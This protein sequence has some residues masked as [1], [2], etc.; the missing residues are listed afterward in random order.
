MT[1]TIRRFCV[2]LS[3]VVAEDRP[4]FKRIDVSPALYDDGAWLESCN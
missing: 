4:D 2:A 1:N 3:Q